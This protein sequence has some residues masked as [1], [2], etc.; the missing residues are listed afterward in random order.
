M[1]H[2]KEQTCTLLIA[3][4]SN[5][6]YC[7]K[8][9]LKPLPAKT[10]LPISLLCIAP[11]LWIILFQFTWWLPSIHVHYTIFLHSRATIFDELE[12]EGC[13]ES[14]ILT[15][16]HKLVLGNSSLAAVYTLPN[17]ITC[18]K[19][20]KY[21]NVTLRQ[22]FYCKDL[23]LLCWNYKRCDSGCSYFLKA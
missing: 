22:I 15:M 11:F 14:N 2:V 13:S 18:L 19:T 20:I 17:T 9:V 23:G 1:M 3:T 16:D 7:T 5:S 10:S 6:R 8:L 4:W 12:Q 21:L